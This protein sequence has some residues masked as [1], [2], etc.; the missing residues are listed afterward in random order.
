MTTI[1]LKFQSLA[2]TILLTALIA[3]A[4]QPQ[5]PQDLREKTASHL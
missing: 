5:N 3:C 4:P 1:S 2:A